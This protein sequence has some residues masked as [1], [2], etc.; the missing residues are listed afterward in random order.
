MHCQP[1]QMNAQ[2]KDLA[3]LKKKVS[4][5]DAGSEILE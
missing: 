1:G 3:E 4:K 2:F 5:Y